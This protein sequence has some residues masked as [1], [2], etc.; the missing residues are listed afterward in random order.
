MH[1]L[2]L[3]K[4]AEYDAA[5]IQ[6]ETNKTLT[7][8]DCSQ[9]GL[10]HNGRVHVVVRHV[11]LQEFYETARLVNW[12]PIEILNFVHL[13]LFLQLGLPFLHWAYMDLAVVDQHKILIVFNRGSNNLQNPFA[14]RRT[15]K[16]AHWKLWK[17][18]EIF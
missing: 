5:L 15:V 9:L 14:F 6:T 17:V 4:T 11:D 3:I 2:H 10:L 12:I 18:S 1:S 16:G 8:A 13:N 7:F